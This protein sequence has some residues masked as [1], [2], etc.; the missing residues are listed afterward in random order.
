MNNRAVDIPFEKKM[1]HSNSASAIIGPASVVEARESKTAE[2][3]SPTSDRVS[4]KLRRRNKTSSQHKRAA[5]S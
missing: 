4:V 5:I 3:T 1:D 2:K